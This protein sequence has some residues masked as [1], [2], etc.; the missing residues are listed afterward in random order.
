[1]GVECDKPVEEES[2][3]SFTI[4]LEDGAAVTYFDLN[5]RMTRVG[6]RSCGG[7]LGS[8]EPELVLSENLY[9]VGSNCSYSIFSSVLI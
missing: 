4:A 2:L 6:R 7:R 1:M 3:V 5:G 9:V 8:H